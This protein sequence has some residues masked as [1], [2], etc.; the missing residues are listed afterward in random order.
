MLESLKEACSGNKG[1]CSLFLHL[2]TPQYNEVI[3]Q[4]NPDTKVAP[5]E[6]LISQIEKIVGE[7]SVSLGNFAV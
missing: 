4:A 1:S 2:K 7:H 6:A 5:T 3:I